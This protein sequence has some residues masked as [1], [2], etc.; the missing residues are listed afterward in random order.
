MIINF[1]KKL[2]K[3]RPL[4]QN[5]RSQTYYFRSINAN[6][7]EAEDYNIT[8]NSPEDKET[9]EKFIKERCQ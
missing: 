5:G 3:K 6:T 4:L 9:L 1:L 2:F 8:T 7:G